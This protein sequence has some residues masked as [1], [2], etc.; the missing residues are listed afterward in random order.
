MVQFTRNKKGLEIFR[1]F[2]RR[3]SIV[4]SRDRNEITARSAIQFACIMALA[5]KTNLLQ[6]VGLKLNCC[7]FF[8]R[9]FLLAVAFY[10]SIPQCNELFPKIS[11]QR[12]STANWIVFRDLF[13][14][15]NNA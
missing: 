2:L 14:L 15:C 13:Y 6:M 12:N 7:L 4:V 1:V 11:N 3:K 10:T 9:G 8:F 5:I